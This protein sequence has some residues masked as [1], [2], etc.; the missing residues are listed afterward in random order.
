M[1]REDCSNCALIRRLYVPPLDKYK[2]IP[3]DAYV[4][5]LFI[6]DP[7]DKT[8]MFMDSKHGMCECFTDIDKARIRDENQRCASGTEGKN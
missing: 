1:N 6:N 2:N 3:K 5:T 4:C 8:V 7:Y